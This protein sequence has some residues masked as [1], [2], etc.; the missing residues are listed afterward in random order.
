[1]VLVS[2]TIAFPIENEGDPH[3]LEM[4]DARA[5]PISVN[6][7]I[8]NEHQDNSELFGN[9]KARTMQKFDSDVLTLDFDNEFL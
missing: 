4:G 8:N 1:L 7:P 2:A 6:Y 3:H 9:R 5:F